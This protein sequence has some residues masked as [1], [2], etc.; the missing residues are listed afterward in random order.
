MIYFI[1][2]GEDGPV[3]IG[4]AR[5]AGAVDTRLRTFQTGHSET[6][7]LLGMRPGDLA[8]EAALHQRFAAARLRGEWFEPTAEL[9]ELAMSEEDSRERW[10]RWGF[11]DADGRLTAAGVVH[12]EMLEVVVRRTCGDDCL[13]KSVERTHAIA[14]MEAEAA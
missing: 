9:L 5:D 11:C 12:V 8:D 7:H 14:E 2:Q 3:K 4:F 1:R 13:E 10:L 6:L